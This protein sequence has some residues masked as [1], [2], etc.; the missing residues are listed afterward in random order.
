MVTG[1]SKTV[2]WMGLNL[3]LPAP[4]QAEKR[5]RQKR[6]VACVRGL[7]GLVGRWPRR[8]APMEQPAVLLGQ[9]GTHDLVCFPTVR[10]RGRQ[11][12]GPEHPRP[13]LPNL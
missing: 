13:S 11:N 12:N 2:C 4:G 3:Q 7:P 6:P 1:R 5:P 8:P 9:R 10:R